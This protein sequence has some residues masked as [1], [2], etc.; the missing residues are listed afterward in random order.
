MFQDLEP[1]H[2]QINN[3][4]PNLT[5]TQPINT[6]NPTPINPVQPYPA[7]LTQRADNSGAPVIVVDR[8]PDTVM[9]T[10]SGSILFYLL[11]SIPSYKCSTIVN[12]VIINVGIFQPVGHF[13]KPLQ[14]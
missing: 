12:C 4:T 7:Y 13:I 9:A 8:E 2:H 14:L 11:N 5:Y 10:P 6:T 1:R 3:S